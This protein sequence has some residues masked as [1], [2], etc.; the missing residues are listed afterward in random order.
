MKRI[1]IV[2]LALMSLIVLSGCS[3]TSDR[4]CKD[5]GYEKKEFV[6]WGRD[7]SFYC[8]KEIRSDIIS[9]SDYHKIVDCYDSNCCDINEIEL[10]Q[11]EKC[12]PECD[13]WWCY[14]ENIASEVKTDDCYQCVRYELY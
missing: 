2:V 4:Y 14:E 5:I 11:E 9:N 1:I 12:Q 10:G 13:L 6:T 3:G 7:M 8:I